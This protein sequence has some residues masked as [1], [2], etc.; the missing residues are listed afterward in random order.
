MH[1]QG[2]ARRILT[3]RVLGIRRGHAVDLDTDVGAREGAARVAVRVGAGAVVLEGAIG[4]EIVEGVVRGQPRVVLVDGGACADGHPLVLFTEVLHRA[5]DDGAHVVPQAELLRARLMHVENLQLILAADGGRRC[6][7]SSCAGLRGRGPRG[8]RIG[9]VGCEKGDKSLLVCCSPAY[10][11]GKRE[12]WRGN[13]ETRTIVWRLAGR[14]GVTVVAGAQC[15]AFGRA[16]GRRVAA[17]EGEAARLI[18]TVAAARGEPAWASADLGHKAVVVADLAVPHEAVGR[19]VCGLDGGVVDV[20]LPRH[21]PDEFHSGF[22]VCELR[23]VL[24]AKTT[25][26]G[27]EACDFRGGCSGEEKRVQ[28]SLSMSLT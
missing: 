24:R 26:V 2:T 13:K 22:G 18:A 20:Q 11:K 15:T 17:R 6:G 21:P 1:R 5:L 8:G 14:L 28:V 25:E 4:V 19:T 9:G 27:N 12:T 10:G 7:S 3:A 23:L 16:R